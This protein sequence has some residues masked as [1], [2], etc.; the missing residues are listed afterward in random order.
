VKISPQQPFDESHPWIKKKLAKIP[1]LIPVFL[2]IEDMSRDGHLRELRWKAI[3][4]D[5][6]FNDE[7]KLWIEPR[8]TTAQG[9]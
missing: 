4:Q 8:K 9:K 1:K 2:I 3:K 6:V 5:F 7:F